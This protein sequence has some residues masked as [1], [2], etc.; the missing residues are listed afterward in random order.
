MGRW[1]TA[2][3]EIKSYF[4]RPL[5]KAITTNLTNLVEYKKK[6]HWTWSM[7]VNGTS[8]FDQNAVFDLAKAADRQRDLLWQFTKARAQ[9]YCESYRLL[10]QHDRPCLT[11]RS[12][13]PFGKRCSNLITSPSY[14]AAIENEQEQVTNGLLPVFHQNCVLANIR[15]GA[16]ALASINKE[17]LLYSSSF[18]SSWFL[19]HE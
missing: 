14:V 9:T 15:W 13:E 2:I 12:R 7:K 5:V 6:T 11:K 4:L 10:R 19:R 8:S 18:S 3:Q 17:G 1:K 16:R